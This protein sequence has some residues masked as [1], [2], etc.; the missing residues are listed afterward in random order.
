MLKENVK[1]F[2]T[3]KLNKSQYKIKKLKNYRIQKDAGKFF[4]EDMLGYGEDVVV[5]VTGSLYWVGEI[6]ASIASLHFPL[7]DLA[8]LK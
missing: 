1:E 5:V 3:R 6:Y 4:G 8:K 7:S 2:L